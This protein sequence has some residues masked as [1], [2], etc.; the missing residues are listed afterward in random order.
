MEV[1]LVRHTAVAVPA[2]TCYGQ[3]EVP[4]RESFPE[5]LAVIRNKIPA[6]I[7]AVY[8][9]PLQRC[10]TLAESLAP[11]IVLDERLKE[12]HFGEWEMQ[13]WNEIDRT[14]LSTWMKDFVRIPAPGGENLQ[15][16]Y[17]RVGAF[18]EELRIRE[19]DK[20][21]VIAHGGVLRCIWAY[22]LKIPLQH[23]FKIPVQ[24][25]EV[26]HFHLGKNM[27]RDYII[28]K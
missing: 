23:V 18:M 1:F 11:D 10:V 27:Y 15:R 16:V 24:Y 21:L 26:L 2:S 8:S 3:S 22:L 12:M 14:V 4:L 25:G 6:G 17:D 5:E 9:S 28:S 13:S 7:A 19:H 20:V